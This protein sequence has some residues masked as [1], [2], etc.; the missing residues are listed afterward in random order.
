MTSYKTS[1]WVQKIYGDTDT[2]YTSGITPPSTLPSTMHRYLTTKPN[3]EYDPDADLKILCYWATD[4]RYT[5]H[6][7][8]MMSRYFAEPS[9]MRV[10]VSGATIVKRGMTILESQPLPETI[11]VPEVQEQSSVKFIHH[12]KRLAAND[13]KCTESSGCMNTYRWINSHTRQRASERTLRSEMIS[14]PSIWRTSNIPAN[15]PE[16]RS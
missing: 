9:R 5:S 3:A 8:T 2:W 4:E 7:T 13:D 1:K 12:L 15:T 14:S 6:S 11:T 16:K 10:V